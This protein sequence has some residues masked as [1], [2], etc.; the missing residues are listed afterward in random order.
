MTWLLYT[1]LFI[2][3]KYIIAIS[4]YNYIIYFN[5]F[6]YFATISLIIKFMIFISSTQNKKIKID[7]N[8]IIY[9]LIISI[10]ININN[11]YKSLR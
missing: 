1:F 6:L 3:I 4:L 2:C 5:Y 10:S 7:K 8:I 11:K 9:I